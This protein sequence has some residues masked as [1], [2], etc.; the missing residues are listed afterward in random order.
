MD[1][2]YHLSVIY[3][4][5]KIAG[6][7]LLKININNFT[8]DRIKYYIPTSNLEKELLDNNSFKALIEKYKGVYVA[9][10]DENSKLIA[11]RFEFAKDE[12]PFMKGINNVTFAD[13]YMIIGIDKECMEYFM[14]V[15]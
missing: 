9:N 5:N 8:F 12:I 4:K 15:F 13:G 1:F 6:E 10:I 11:I 14:P 7:N 2:S 3:V